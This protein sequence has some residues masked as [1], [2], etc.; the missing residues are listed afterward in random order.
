M[1]ENTSG[2]SAQ[3]AGTSSQPINATAQTQTPSPAVAKADK[4]SST[5]DKGQKGESRGRESLKAPARARHEER[6]VSPGTMPDGSHAT[7]SGE[8][9]EG[10]EPG[11]LSKLKGVFSIGKH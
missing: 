2:K 1:I 9:G 6:D 5:S 4:T 8:R 7:T 10:Y 11:R 3:T